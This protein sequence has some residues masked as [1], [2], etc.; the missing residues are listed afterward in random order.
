[1]C[2]RFVGNTGHPLEKRGKV[3]LLD[4]G[5]VAGRGSN[6]NIF[7]FSHAWHNFPTTGK[8]YL[9]VNAKSV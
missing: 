1:M 6:N 3:Q 2:Q 4:G 7:L 8:P 9:L 5:S